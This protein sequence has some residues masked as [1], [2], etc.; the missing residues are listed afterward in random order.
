MKYFIMSFI[1]KIAKKIRKHFYKE[2]AQGMSQE[3]ARS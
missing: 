1:Q 3:S 2:P